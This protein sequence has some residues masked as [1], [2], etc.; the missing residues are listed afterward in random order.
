MQRKSF[1]NISNMFK[2]TNYKNKNKTY[3]YQDNNEIYVNRNSSGVSFKKLEYQE[4]EFCTITFNKNILY[5]YTDFLFINIY[6]LIL[7]VIYKIWY[8]LLLI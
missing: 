3:E 4:F 6:N 2:N 7:F 1:Q 5:L 8:L